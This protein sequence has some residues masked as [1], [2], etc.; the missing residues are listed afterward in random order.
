MKCIEGGIEG[1]GGG[2]Q[3]SC[4]HRPDKGDKES[5]VDRVRSEVSESPEGSRSVI[6]ERRE[7]RRAGEVDKRVMNKEMRQSHKGGSA[8]VYQ[9]RLRR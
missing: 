7:H 9:P 5:K 3:C 1:R 8:I 6:H 4:S 2:R